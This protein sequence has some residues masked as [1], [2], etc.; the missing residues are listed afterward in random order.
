M[1]DTTTVRIG[2]ASARELEIAVDDADAIAATFEKAV[3]GKDTVMW[4]TD[5]RGHRF[6][7][8]VNSI[9]FV[10]IDQPEDRGVGF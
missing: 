1:S 9:A 3:K 8:N 2:L 6:G 5:T 4:V 7:I 10:E